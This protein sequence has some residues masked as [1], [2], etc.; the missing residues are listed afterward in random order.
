MKKQK[1]KDEEYRVI[2]QELNEQ[3]LTIQK[4]KRDLD[5][6]IGKMTNNKSEEE[7]KNNRKLDEILQVNNQI[8]EENESIKEKYETIFVEKEHL[9]LSLNEC[10]NKNNGLNRELAREVLQKEKLFT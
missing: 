4:Q 7:Q 8:R 2:I 1:S 9:Y 6:L 5:G 3:M 10:Q